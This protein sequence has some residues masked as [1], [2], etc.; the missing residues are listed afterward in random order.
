MADRALVMEQLTPEMTDAGR[1][2]LQRLEQDGMK[3]R[4]ALW[5]LDG[6]NGRWSLVLASPDVRTG[7]SLPL[8]KKASKHLA[9]MGDPDYL[10]VYRVAIVDP[11]STL[12]PLP[13]GSAGAV[14]GLAGQRV[15]NGW[16]GEAHVDD[17]CVYR[18]APRRVR[19]TA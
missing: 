8:Y 9:R 15:T 7:G 3:I 2:L 4:T 12:V 10:P 5:L 11:K 1:D 14:R 17:A 19:A 16:V 13:S 6:E 18:V